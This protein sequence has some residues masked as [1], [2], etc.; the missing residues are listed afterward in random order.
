MLG[1]LLSNLQCLLWTQSLRKRQEPSSAFAEL[2]SW[3]IL[4]QAASDRKRGCGGV[5]FTGTRV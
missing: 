5:A 3:T 4:K 1:N 2:K